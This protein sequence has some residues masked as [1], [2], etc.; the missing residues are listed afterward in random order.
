MWCQS[1]HHVGE[2]FNIPMNSLRTE[3]Q[4]QYSAKYSAYMFV[5]PLYLC[6]NVP[7]PSFLC[8]VALNDT[9]LIRQKPR[10]Y[11]GLTHKSSVVIHCLHSR[12]NLSATVEWYK[13]NKYDEDQEKRRRIN[14]ER[15]RIVIYHSNEATLRSILQIFSPRI[16]DTGVYFCK[17]ND[18]W[19]PGTEVQV[20]SKW[21]ELHVFYADQ[22]MHDALLLWLAFPCISLRW[23]LPG[24]LWKH[25]FPTYIFPLTGPLLRDKALYRSNMKDGL[26]VLQGLLLAVCIA[27]VLLRKRAMVR[28]RRK[29]WDKYLVSQIVLLLS[30]A[31]AW[32]LDGMKSSWLGLQH[33]IIHQQL[34]WQLFHWLL[35]CN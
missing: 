11:G 27:A 5:L 7:E 32:E 35:A 29:T 17:L 3:M 28:M 26:I 2:A 6:H 19:G 33:I 30:E 24:H 18:T 1:Q 22:Q 25:I 13:V 23:F 10:F 12:Q 31:V 9:H 4:G 14:P 15:R 16:T 8:S 34:H 21:L 20:T